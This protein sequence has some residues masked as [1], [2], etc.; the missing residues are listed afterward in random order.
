MKRI[1]S[2]L[3]I[4]T[5]LLRPAHANNRHMICKDVGNIFDEQAGGPRHPVRPPPGKRGPVGP[6]GPKGDQGDPGE[7]DYSIINE[8]IKEIVKAQIQEQLSHFSSK[9]NQNTQATHVVT[10]V[11]RHTVCQ[12]EGARAYKNKC[13]WLIL[14]TDNEYGFSGA[15]KLCSEAGGEPGDVLD[16]QHYDM[17][18]EM[19][20]AQSPGT[21]W[22]WTGMDINPTTKVAR[23]SDGSQAQFVKW[24]SSSYPS[25]SS[26]DN[27]IL[28]QIEGN[29]SGNQ[30]MYNRPASNSAYGAFCQL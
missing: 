9:M 2:Y 21:R 18:E 29:T 7:V 10:S 30:G 24:Y 1:I 11:E 20:R 19:F 22:F 28:I 14:K 15:Q 23:Y 25:T 12:M 4:S 13:Y 16:Q 17:I 3:L 26:S 27:R 8:T 5:F 6:P